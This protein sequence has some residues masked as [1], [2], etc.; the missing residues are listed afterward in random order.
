MNTKVTAHTSTVAWSLG[1]E[2]RTAP[3]VVVQ[4]DSAARPQPTDL[5]T[6]LPEPEPALEAVAPQAASSGWSQRRIPRRAGERAS[7]AVTAGPSR[8]AA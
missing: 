6:F 3:L 5:P 2:R 4:R 7:A 1:G 8:Q